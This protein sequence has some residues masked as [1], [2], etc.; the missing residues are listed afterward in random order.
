MRT[1]R[2]TAHWLEAARR[3]RRETTVSS[4]S[5]AGALT[6]RA[7]HTSTSKTDGQSS[8]HATAAR[9]PP[10]HTLGQRPRLS[11]LC[12]TSVVQVSSTDAAHMAVGPHGKTRHP[13]RTHQPG[14]KQP[15]RTHAKPSRHARI[16]LRRA[17]P[18]RDLSRDMTC[19]SRLAANAPIVHA[20]IQGSSRAARRIH[21]AR[22]RT[23]I[24]R[25]S[26]RSRQR[27]GRYAR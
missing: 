12:P 2:L 23:T 1:C 19:P 6:Q 18:H 26:H 21:H 13:A 25:D 9:P 16:F 4:G 5:V 17:T 24:S 8:V 10:P 7:G 3:K 15:G 22:S 11:R 27:S 14:A 20:Y